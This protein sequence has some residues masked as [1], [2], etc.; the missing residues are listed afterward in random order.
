M[1]RLI[2]R[3]PS[4][5]ADANGRRSIRLRLENFRIFRDSGWFKLAPLTCIVGRNSSGKSSVLSAILLLKQ[6]I[7]REAMGSSLMPLA[8]A[9]PYCDLGNYADIVH[10]HNESSEIS[11]SVS[12]GLADLTR[13]QS[14]RSTPFVEFTVPRRRQL[15]YGYYYGGST[16]AK[17]PE[18]GEINARLTFSVDEPFGPS[19]SRFELAVTGVG[20]ANFVRTISGE[21][22]EHWRV[23][24]ASLP[25]KSLALVPTGRDVFFPRVRVRQASY[26][27]SSPTAKHRIRVFAT[28]T[29]MLFR[30]LQQSLL[31]SEVVGPFRT[32][33]ERRYTFGG[34]GSSGGGTSGEQAVDLLIT[35]ALLKSEGDRPL[36]S[37]L[38]F[39]IR[40]LKLAES[41]DVKDIA[42]RL[43]LFEVDITGAG[44]GTSANL[45]DVGFGVS[46]VLPVLVQGLLMRRGG[47]YLVQQPEIHLHPDAQAGLADFFIYLASYGVVTVV[48]T[49]SEYLLL[50]LRRRLAEGAGP[51]EAGLSIEDPNVP[52]LTTKDVAVLFTGPEGADAGVRELEIGDAFQF[53]NLPT[54]FMSQALDDRIA[55]LDAVGKRNA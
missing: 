22:R 8:L 39:W 32:P 2:T 24:T 25:P 55:L 45:A 43:N 41:F 14:E 3:T 37:A 54:G 40:H 28:A 34:F 27:R 7:E 44:T 4:A 30:F 52:P 29:G 50:R 20:S 15:G 13:A 26:G 10:N 9:G 38:S 17:L 18:K 46:Q 51:V 42:K 49:H 23:Y 31:R 53:E 33:P 16:D 11:L 5:N 35:E 1:R 36:H 47:I 19:L 48:E 21:R 12:V 6:S